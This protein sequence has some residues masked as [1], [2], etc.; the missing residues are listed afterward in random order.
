[1]EQED[2]SL[3]HAEEATPLRTHRSRSSLSPRIAAVLVTVS[4]VASL[5]T[6][7]TPGMASRVAFLERT[8]PFPTHASRL[9]SA[10]AG[11]AILMLARGLWWRKRTAWTLAVALLA[12]VAFGDI[13]RAFDYEEALL[14]LA[15]AVWLVTQHR[16]FYARADT[17]SIAQG[18]RVLVAAF[19]VTIAYGAIGF[20]LLDRHFSVNF[21]LGAAI[22]QTIVMF[23]SFYD[24]HLNTI[25]C[26][27]RYFAASIYVVAAAAFGY[28]LLMLLRPV[29][30][31][32]PATPAEHRRAEQI[33]MEYGRTPLARLALLPDK[34]YRFGPGGTVIAYA[35]TGGVGL[36][37]GDPIGPADAVPGAI[38][39]FTEMCRTNGWRPAFYQ[40]PP[41][42][43]ADYRAARFSAVAVGLD[44]VVDTAA[45]ALDGRKYGSL[46]SR[47]R[48]LERDGFSA[49][50]LRPPHMHRLIGELRLV[51]DAWLDHIHGAEKAFSLGWFDEGYVRSV[52]V[53]V[54]R[55]SGGEVEAFATLSPEYQRNGVAV[56]LMRYTPS[57]PSGVM[58]Y[59]FVRLI[60]WARDEGIEFVDLGL[61]ALAGVGDDPADPAAEKALRLVYEY[62]NDFYGFK[63]LHEYKDKFRPGWEPRY[64]IYKDATGLP[65]VLAAVVRAN[66]GESPGSGLRRHLRRLGR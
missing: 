22:R 21:G 3:E 37:L 23:T 2:L 59:L 6:A 52:P 50:V 62:G 48:A 13:F 19:A 55:G 46:R 34:A 65:S 58:D 20:F 42:H 10:L 24:P 38:A 25:T 29:L 26:F 39:D 15:F 57:A 64:L 9:A 5:V 32:R 41:D 17:P 36:S 66:A 60:E 40:T 35:V 44:A 43:L 54:V 63:G 28:A 51:S 61:S 11:V 4:G 14:I 27:G 53:M 31:R 7:A 8:L 12:V 16:A 1:M 47:N 49:S 33:V 56:D 30:I 45:F 18:L